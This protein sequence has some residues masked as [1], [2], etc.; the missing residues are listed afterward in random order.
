MT[1]YEINFVCDGEGLLGRVVKG[2]L[3]VQ[4]CS[5]QKTPDT[6]KAWRRVRDLRQWRE[7][8][9]KG[10]TRHLCPTCWNQFIERKGR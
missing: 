2:C 8:R 7:A 3:S 10:K 6:T 4:S 5:P 9:W 1:T